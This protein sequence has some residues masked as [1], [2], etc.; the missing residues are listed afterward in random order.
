MNMKCW[1][2]F[3]CQQADN[4]GGDQQLTDDPP[5]ETPNKNNYLELNTYTAKLLSGGSI[6]PRASN[7]SSTY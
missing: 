1:L 3:G 6:P 2:P 4:S 5:T 7:L